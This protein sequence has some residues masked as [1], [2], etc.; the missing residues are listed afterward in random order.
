M[1]NWINNLP[2]AMQIAVVVI[3]VLALALGIAL[4]R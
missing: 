4:L 1:I 2:R 3:V